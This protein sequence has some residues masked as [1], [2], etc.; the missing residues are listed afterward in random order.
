MYDTPSQNFEAKAVLFDYQSWV[1][2]QRSVE[3]WMNAVAE[4]WFQP[5]Q[6]APSGAGWT[7]YIPRIK[8]SNQIGQLKIKGFLISNQV[9]VTAIPNGINIQIVWSVWTKLHT[10]LHFP[11]PTTFTNTD[12]APPFIETNLWK[13]WS[14]PKRKTTWRMLWTF[15][16][17]KLGSRGK[18]LWKLTGSEFHW[19]VYEF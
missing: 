8:A 19:L 4:N 17:W 7:Q 11:W 1:W 13:F 2:C 15:G 9:L 18:K 5:L 6:P 3:C 14:V 12:F 10:S 16:L